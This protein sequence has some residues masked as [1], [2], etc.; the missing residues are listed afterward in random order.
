MELNELPQ[1]RVTNIKRRKKDYSKRYVVIA[2]LTVALG[3]GA[4]ADFTLNDAKIMTKISSLFEHKVEQSA[5]ITRLMNLTSE[6]YNALGLDEKKQALLVRWTYFKDEILTLG[7]CDVYEAKSG[8]DV[9]YIDA[10]TLN[11]L[12]ETGRYD[13]IA[14]ESILIG[15]REV[16]I[17]RKGKLV[18]YLDCNDLT[19]V[20]TLGSEL[21][22]EVVTVG[23]RDLVCDQKGNLKSYLDANTLEVI[24]PFCKSVTVYEP[25][26]GYVLAEFSDGTWEIIDL[27]EQLE[28]TIEEGINLK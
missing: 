17:A 18:A 7:N 9:A 12:I 1:G 10:H 19:E 27:S 14:S 5:E 16:L 8:T 3:G 22:G 26:L 13:S 11:E 4:I 20:K 6:E 25:A 21:N 24:I 23:N 15:N 28:E 2:L